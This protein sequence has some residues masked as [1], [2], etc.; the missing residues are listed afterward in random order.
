MLAVVSAPLVA[1]NSTNTYAQAEALLLQASQD[2]AT[3]NTAKAAETLT[4]VLQL[5]PSIPELTGAPETA[6]RSQILFQVASQYAVLGQFD[7]ALSVAN[8][9]TYDL[10]KVSAQQAIA[11]RYL[12]LGQE[13]QALDIINNIADRFEQVRSLREVFSRYYTG[14]RRS[15]ASLAVDRALE[16]TQK[17]PANQTSKYVGFTKDNLL[18]WLAGD[19]ALL[20]NFQKA[21]TVANSIK[22][23]YS[24]SEAQGLILIAYLQ[25]GNPD[26]ALQYAQT[27]QSDRKIPALRNTAKKYAELGNTAKANQ[28]LTQAYELAK[29]TESFSVAEYAG[30]YAEIGQRDRAIQLVNSISDDY[31]KA[32]G[33]QAIAQADVNAGNYRQALEMVKLIPDRILMPFSRYADP[34]VELL[35]DIA[36]KAAQVADV[37]LALLSVKSLP[38]GKDRVNVTTKVAKELAKVGQKEQASTVLLQALEMAQATEKVLVYSEGSGT[39]IYASNARLL[40][41]LAGDFAEIGQ[42]NLAADALKLAIRQAQSED[43]VSAQYSSEWSDAQ[44]Q[45]LQTLRYIVEQSAKLG[46]QD[47]VNQ[48]LA[49][50]L[51]MKAEGEGNITRLQEMSA[52]AAASGKLGQASARELL[53]HTAQLAKK[54]EI[55]DRIVTEAKIAAAYGQIGDHNQA[56][57]ILAKITPEVASIQQIPNSGPIASYRRGLALGEI[58]VAYVQAEQSELA[59]AALNRIEIEDLKRSAA[60]NTVQA[61]IKMGQVPQVLPIA[62]A[63]QDPQVRSAANSE[64]VQAYLKDKQPAL[65]LPVAQMITEANQKA[66]ALAQVALAY[67]QVGQAK[68]ASPILAQAL[69]AVKNESLEKS[70]RISALGDIAIGYAAMGER[71]QATAILNQALQLA[72]TQ[73][74]PVDEMLAILTT[75]VKAGQDDLAIQAIQALPDDRFKVTAW[76]QMA[77][78]Y[79][80]ADRATTALNQARQIAQSLKDTTARDNFLNAIAQQ[81]RGFTA[82]N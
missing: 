49:Q 25:A 76:R 18:S 53:G 45:K 55:G 22:E 41:Q 73:T 59:I 11:Y 82:R 54:L 27:L 38:D 79:P 30:A 65:A 42:P 36:I 35:G 58:A 3:G 15:L 52:I 1:Q 31:G 19:Y 37:N 26:G 43:R 48:A 23:P 24:I 20:G 77:Q 46:L 72:R 21:Q 66:K 81:Q 14:D 64:I 44:L 12:D 10:W 80:S 62:Q 67:T 9:I 40:N 33:R 7:R 70:D 61:S 8:S 47:K 28:V 78:L 63:I 51:Q 13:S 6:Q 50:T 32:T 29:G 74:Y 71:Q 75:A 69:S 17:I 60:L 57:E 34:K 4:K 56:Q 2:A 16:I 39:A 68:A 5:A